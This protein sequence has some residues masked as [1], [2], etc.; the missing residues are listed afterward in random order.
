[1][2]YFITRKGG[3]IKVST[4]KMKDYKRFADLHMEASQKCGSLMLT[5]VEAPKKHSEIPFYIARNVL[6]TISLA[7]H[8]T[9]CVGTIKSKV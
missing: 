9:P 4:T 5:K 3:G 7:S 1:M 2:N 8:R 6:G